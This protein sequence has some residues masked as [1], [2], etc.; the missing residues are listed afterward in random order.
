MEKFEEPRTSEARVVQGPS[1]SRMF[2][3]AGGCAANSLSA[4]A[5]RRRLSCDPCAPGSAEHGEQ[6]L[7]TFRLAAV[8]EAARRAWLRNRSVGAVLDFAGESLFCEKS[9]TVP[10][11]VYS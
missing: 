2:R 10:G 8:D 3:F 7:K 6:T 9:E 1:W 4:A 5:R 11:R